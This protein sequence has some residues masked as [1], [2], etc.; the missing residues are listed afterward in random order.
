MSTQQVTIRKMPAATLYGISHVGPYEA[1]APVF[2]KLAKIAETEK[3]SYDSGVYIGL[4]YD[5][6]DTNPPAQLRSKACFMPHK[7]ETKLVDPAIST[8]QFHEGEYAVYLYK[9]AYEGL[10]NAWR[11]FFETWFPTSGRQ[12]IL[13]DQNPT[14]ELYLNECGKVANEELLTELMLRL[15]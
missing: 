2:G 8:Y 5:N 7:P 3:V 9:G 12:F 11:W 14:F 6:P 1:I 10:P 15:K 13:N 4:Y